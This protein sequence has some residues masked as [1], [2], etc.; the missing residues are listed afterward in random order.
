MTSSPECLSLASHHGGA[1]DAEAGP[2]NLA[3]LRLQKVWEEQRQRL[4]API[5]GAKGFLSTE[6]GVIFFWDS[7]WQDPPPKKKNHKKAP[8]ATTPEQQKGGKG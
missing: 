7:P 5:Y 1:M 8:S 2:Q 4:T 6:V 3:F